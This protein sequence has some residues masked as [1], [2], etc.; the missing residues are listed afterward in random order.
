MILIIKKNLIDIQMLA[1]KAKRVNKNN[2]ESIKI[3]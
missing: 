1:R 3:N 2:L